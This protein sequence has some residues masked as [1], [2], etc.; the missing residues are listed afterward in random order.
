AQ[1]HDSV[2]DLDGHRPRIVLGPARARL[3]RRIAFGF[4]PLAQLLDPGAGDVVVAGHFAFAA[5]L[6]H[7][8]GDNELRLRHGRPPRLAEMP[9]MSRDTCQLCPETRPCRMPM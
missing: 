9:T 8:G 7:D 3:K 4:I 1:Q 6:E 5:S 2:F